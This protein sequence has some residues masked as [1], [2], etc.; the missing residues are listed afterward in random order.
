MKITLIPFRFPHIIIRK[1]KE[2][3]EAIVN[4]MNFFKGMGTGLIV[5]ACIGMATAPD[6]KRGKKTLEKAVKAV[7]TIVGDVS[8]LIGL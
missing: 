6:K 8:D 5:G 4:S 7:E 3:E 2:T 1:S